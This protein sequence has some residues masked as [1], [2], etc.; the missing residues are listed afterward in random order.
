[1]NKTTLFIPK[2]CK[3]GFQLR[4]DTFSGKLGYII[5]H[6]GK[7]WRKEDSWNSWKH[8]Y[9]TPEVFEQKKQE[10]FKNKLNDC[11]LTFE[12]YFQKEK[13]LILGNIIGKKLILFRI[14]M[15]I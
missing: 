14:L 4:N 15:N 3:V 6:D 13:I 1:M 2:K 12:K 11:T 5:Y 7:V 9:I 8:D 10:E